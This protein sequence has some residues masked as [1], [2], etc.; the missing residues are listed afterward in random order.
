MVGQTMLLFDI[1]PVV[2]ST[3]TITGIYYDFLIV[4]VVCQLL[5]AVFG[6]EVRVSLEV[7]VVLP[8]IEKW[9]EKESHKKQEE[10]AEDC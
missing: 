1:V 3:S 6:N 5:M 9:H 2:C 8:A 7:L 10:A 4:Y